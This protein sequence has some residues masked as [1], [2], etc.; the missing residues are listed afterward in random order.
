MTNPTPVRRRDRDPP[1]LHAEAGST[2]L[3]AMNVDVNP[4]THAGF[5]T[6]P[7]STLTLIHDVGRSPH[8]ERQLGSVGYG[9][10]ARRHRK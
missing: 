10:D 1:G 2:L 4:H 8:L 7:R 6:N 9:V 3:I 5:H